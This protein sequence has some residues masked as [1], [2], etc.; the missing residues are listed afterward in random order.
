MPER[1]LTTLT[2][3]ISGVN[4]AKSKKNLYSKADYKKVTIKTSDGLT[5][6]G[7]INQTPQDRVSDLFTQSEAPFVVLVDVSYREGEGKILIVNKR[8][9]VW[10]EPEDDGKA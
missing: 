10:V 4:L 8:H 7:L 9:I 2:I 3:K 1:R 5:I 6:Q